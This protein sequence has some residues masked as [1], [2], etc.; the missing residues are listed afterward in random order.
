VD[1]A[2]D[3]GN[4]YDDV[5]LPVTISAWI[6]VDEDAVSQNPIFVSQ[7]GDGLY[8]GFWMVINPN[9][10]F[11]GYGDGQGQNNS[12]YRRDKSSPH[13]LEFGEWIHVASV[14]NTPDDI[15]V[16]LNGMP[17]PGGYYGSSAL[18]M[19][20]QFP[21]ENARIGNWLSNGINYWFK[22]T[23]DDI[24]IWNR[25]LSSDEIKRE[26]ETRMIGKEDLI[27]HW[28]F[29]EKSGEKAFDRSGNNLHGLLIGNPERIR[30]N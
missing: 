26:N 15:E 17:L 4:I 18:P 23:I 27:G 30:V 11:A 9:D 16:Y 8:N 29:N 13:N 2:V 10:L 1:D 12:A 24:K 3:L 6:K 20:S 7:S 19:A 21:E 28:D 14:I 25:A 22:G 5:Q